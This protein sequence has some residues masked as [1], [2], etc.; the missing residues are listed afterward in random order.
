MGTRERLTEAAALLIHRKG[1]AQTTLADIAAAAEVPLGSIYYHF[2]TKD[3]V[4]RAILQ[5]RD[6]GI[7]RML[8]KI[9]DLPDPRARLEALVGVW[10]DDREID[11]RYGCPVGSLCYE[12]AKGRGELSSGAAQPLKTLLAWSESQFRL[13][14]CPAQRATVLALHMVAALQGI[15]LIANALG[16]PGSIMTEAAFLKDWLRKC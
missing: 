15:S 6:T 1:F 14:G 10:I 11:A 7:G 8:A 4:A 13:I 16:D 5:R 9:D 2:K 3:D 12:L